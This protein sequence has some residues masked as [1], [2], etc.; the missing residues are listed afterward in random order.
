MNKMDKYECFDNIKKLLESRG[1]QIDNKKEINY[2]I[3]FKITWQQHNGVY[4]IYQ[5]KKGIRL[6][7]SQ[8]KDDQF[9]NYIDNIIENALCQLSTAQYNDEK[10]QSVNYSDKNNKLNDPQRIIGIDESGKGD[11]FGPLVIAGVY[12]DENTGKILMEAGVTDSK[13]LQDKRIGE[14]AKIIKNI[15]PFDIV[16]ISNEKYNQ[17]YDSIKNLNKLLAW[18]HARVIENLLEQVN[19]KYALS[20]QFGRPE[21][22]KEALMSKGRKIQLEQRTKAEENIAVAAASILA[23]NEFVEKINDLECQ[24]QTEFP[25]GASTQVVA[26]ANIFAQQYGL[27]AIKK[28][29]KVHFKITNQ[30]NLP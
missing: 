24:Y 19:C 25:K 12:T 17:L 18:G 22:I 13:K 28:V 30:I 4:R 15:C 11:Y 2:G 5:S 23:R 21:L 7:S 8:I 1:C 26:A 27:D 9:R 10:E 3:Q 14:L 6:D 20:D 16:V 29:A